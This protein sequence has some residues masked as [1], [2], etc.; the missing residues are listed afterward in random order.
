MTQQETINMIYEKYFKDDSIPSDNWC[1]LCKHSHSFAMDGMGN[2]KKKNDD[3][4][5]YCETCEMFLLDKEKQ[6]RLR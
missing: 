5:F 4:V 6:K 1:E 2:C 3:L